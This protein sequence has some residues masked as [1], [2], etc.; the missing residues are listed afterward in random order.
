MD[1]KV[2]SS[3]SRNTF[4]TEKI[5]LVDVDQLNDFFGILVRFFIALA[6]ILFTVI[7]L[8]FYLFLL[9]SLIFIELILSEG[10]LEKSVCPIFCLELRLY[11]ALL[12]FCAKL[13]SGWQYLPGM[14]RLS[15][16]SPP[17]DLFFLELLFLGLLLFVSAIAANLF[18]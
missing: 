15:S 13:V 14:R 16:R 6:I 1:G 8:S 10:D 4:D 11:F 7:V 3:K 18:D 5:G 9:G 2:Y 17:L 12:V